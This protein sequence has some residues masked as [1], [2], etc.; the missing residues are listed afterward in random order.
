MAPLD[1]GSQ[2]SKSL[3]LS[4]RHDLCLPTPLPLPL[5][6]LPTVCLYLGA[7]TNPPSL[8]FE[9]CAKSSLDMLLRAGLRHPQVHLPSVA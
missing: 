2:E 5:P 3:S 1:V 4:P 8:V 7:C 6:R 9:Y